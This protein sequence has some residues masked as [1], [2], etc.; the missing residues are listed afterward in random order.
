MKIVVGRAL[1]RE[2]N[3]RYYYYYYL[4]YFSIYFFFEQN[5]FPLNKYTLRSVFRRQLSII[6]DAIW[7][8]NRCVR[9]FFIFKKIKIS[10]FSIDFYCKPT[11]HQ[12]YYTK[13]RKLQLLIVTTSHLQNERKLNVSLLSLCL[14]IYWHYI[15]RLGIILN[16]CVRKFIH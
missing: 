2:R 13:H 14:R 12:S 15:L 16:D 4:L 10:D 6:S 11:R 1:E 9:H 3:R 8:E 7:N 5:W